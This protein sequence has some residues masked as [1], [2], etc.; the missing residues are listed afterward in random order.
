MKNI[1]LIRKYSINFK[2]MDIKE[3]EIQIERLKIGLKNSARFEEDKN[4]IYMI[5][6]LQKILDIPDDDRKELFRM[7][8][9]EAKLL[10][11][12][13]ITAT[14]A[15]IFGGGFMVSNS[16]LPNKIPHVQTIS[17]IG[18]AITLILMLRTYWLYHLAT[19]IGNK[20]YNSI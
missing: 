16:I 7:C 15:V 10:K 9:I 8:K 19:K 12:V 18:G 13:K 6:D 17:S 20:F 14:M 3:I 11:Y 4:S 1:E 2:N 5:R